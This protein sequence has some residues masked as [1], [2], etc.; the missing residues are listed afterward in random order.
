LP[1]IKTSVGRSFM[2]TESRFSP[3][4]LLGSRCTTRVLFRTM[5]RPAGFSSTAAANAALV[6]ASVRQIASVS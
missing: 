4:A 6:R 1:K 3:V 5:N 2:L